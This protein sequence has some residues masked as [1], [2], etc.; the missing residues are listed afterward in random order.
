MLV[1]VIDDPEELAALAP[2]WW[3]LW[4]R[5]GAGPFQSPAWLLPWIDVF[6]S[7]R[8][9]ALVARREGTLAGLLPLYARDEADGR[10]LRPCGIGASDYL[11]GVFD[12]D[13][14]DAVAAA[15]LVRLGQAEPGAFLDLPRLPRESPLARVPVSSGW[16]D[17]REP[18][19]PCPVLALAADPGALPAALPK[20]MAQNLRYYRRRAEA[21][22]R[23]DIRRAGWEDAP[24][25]F[26]TVAALHRRRWQGRGEGGVLDDPAVR[27]FH[28]AAVPALAEAGLLRLYTLTLDGTPLAALYALAT[29]ST[30]A[31]YIGGFDPA[32]AG[33]GVGTLLIGHAVAEAAAEGAREFDFL[34][35]R[36]PYK[37]LWGA[38]DRA[39]VDRWLRLPARPD[40]A[41]PHA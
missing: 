33:L 2:A 25:S 23:L 3:A 21:A 11:D 8:L 27:R 7:G 19:E 1:S 36:E 37:Y 39:V 35:G 28:A 32:A 29:G 18:G 13:G 4:R 22:G 10:R 24:A 17:R 15:M 14:A 41:P 38:V 16:D 34:R 5:A 6:R 31:Y 9:V 30:T 12:P 20:R 26:E 40:G